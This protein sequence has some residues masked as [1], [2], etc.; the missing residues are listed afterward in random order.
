VIPE[1]LIIDMLK[2]HKIDLCLS[3][4]CISIQQLILALEQE[5][6]CIALTR[7]EEGVG[8]A[9]GA[10]LAGHRPIMIIQSGGMGNSLN[11]LLSLTQFY[12]MPLP[13][14][15]SWRGIY[16]EKL[17]AQKPMGQHIIGILEGAGIPYVEVHSSG[18]LEKIEDG[19]NK[20]YKSQTPVAI[21]LSPAVFEGSP[22]DLK[23]EYPPRSRKGKFEHKTNFPEPQM[24]RYGAISSITDIIKG[25]LVISNLGYPS[26][27]LYAI[28]DQP[29][30]F[31]MLG[32][33]GLASSIG[34]GV[35]LFTKKDV[36]II[37]GDGSL[38]AN[39]NV[40]LSMGRYG[41]SNLIVIA[42]DNGTHGSTGDERTGAYDLFDL[43][44]LA[45]ACNIT[46]TA[47]VVTK[48]ELRD[49]LKNRDKGTRFI[50]VIITPGNK[51]V[52][53]IPLGPAQI[54]ERF[55]ESI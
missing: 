40:L 7:E 2:R 41:P 44:L 13:M 46:N 1:A 47:K 35:S 20:A 28:R 49:A 19:I 55:M 18:E 36:I 43:E 32:S 24:D 14:L 22:S 3:L 39:P 38:L 10:Y 5:F 12:R 4:P 48:D 50:H 42:M 17:A 33:F 30:N 8:I 26:R 53:T 15:I 52:G 34:L 21:L 37:D 16:K 31:Y 6:K 54:K 23:E 51:G 11:A 27:E 45:K 25:K 9:A 29:T